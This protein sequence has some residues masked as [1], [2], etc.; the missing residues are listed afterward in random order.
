MLVII[1]IHRKWRKNW[2]IYTSSTTLFKSFEILPFHFGNISS[3]ATC[4][5]S[6]WMPPT[7][8]QWCRFLCLLL[9]YCWY[10]YTNLS[11]WDRQRQVRRRMG[12]IERRRGLAMAPVATL[13]IFFKVFLNKHKLHN[14]IKRKFY[15]LTTTTIKK[16]ANT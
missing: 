15:I 3:S 14:L 9:M 16:Y 7:K 6:A 10:I 1:R 11:P 2:L 12:L 4:A 13:G 8:P 5:R